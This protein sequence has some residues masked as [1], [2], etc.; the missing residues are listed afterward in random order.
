MDYN[1][2]K[3]GEFYMSNVIMYLVWIW[4]LHGSQKEKCCIFKVQFGSVAKKTDLAYK[5]VYLER[6]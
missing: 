3:C 4:M 5:S 6:D 1:L 2:I